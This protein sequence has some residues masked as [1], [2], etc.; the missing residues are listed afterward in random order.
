MG[1]ASDIT[2]R[3]ARAVSRLLSWIEDNDPRAPAELKEIYRHSGNSYLL[4]ITGPPGAGKSTLADRLISHYRA[5]NL[6][7]GVLAFDPSSPF[8]G[9]AV[10]GDRIRMQQHATDSGVFIRSMANRNWP[11]GIGRAAVECA[12]VLDAFGCAFIIVETVGVGQGDVDVAR[13]AYTTLLVVTPAAGDKIQAMKAGVIEAADI[14]VLNKA[15]LPDAEHAAKSLEMILGIHP[16]GGWQVPL[17][18]AVAR[19]GEGTGD[20]ADAIDRHRRF[21]KQSGALEEKKQEGLRNH[22]LDI[23]HRKCD[24]ALRLRMTSD[25]ELDSYAERLFR[26]AADPYSLAEEI[27]RKEIKI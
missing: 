2:N 20:V 16:R 23:V 17:V 13:L 25:K 19:E 4:G 6:R 1:L 3:D 24:E 10:L 11:G 8:S 15:D 18:R 22:L 21:I 12:R 7:V 27:I 9:G 14:V 5:A 26:G